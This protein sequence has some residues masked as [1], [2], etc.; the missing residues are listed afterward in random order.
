MRGA[1][2][3]AL[4]CVWLLG[5]AAGAWA[6]DAKPA[7]KAEPGTTAQSACIA[8]DTGWTRRGSNGIDLNVDLANRCAEPIDCRVF[9]YVTT[10]K[11]AA[12]GSGSLRL[13][14]AGQP[15]AKQ[16]FTMKVPMAGGSVQSARECRVR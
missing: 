6:E 12:K 10:A 14:G 3:S 11:G 8:Q 16:R 2:R 9:V 5:F 15:R 1:A 4:G 7:P 13:S